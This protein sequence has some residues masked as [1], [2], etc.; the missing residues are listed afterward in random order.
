[1]N[2][3]GDVKRKSERE[4]IVIL[5]ELPMLRKWIYIVCQLIAGHLYPSIV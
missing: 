3:D 4:Y 2:D 5:L 1:M